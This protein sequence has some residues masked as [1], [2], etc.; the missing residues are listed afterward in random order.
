[1][2]KNVIFLLFFIFFISCKDHSQNYKK[3][4]LNSLIEVNT[5]EDSLINVF[6]EP[7]R[8]SIESE[9]NE[10]IS[11][12][13][14]DLIKNKPVGNLGNFITNLCLSY[15]EADICIM[16]NGGLRSS[17]NKGNITV[18][19]IYELMPFENEL[20]IVELS[21]TDFFEMLHHIIIEKGGEPISGVKVVATNKEIIDYKPKFKYEKKQ[22][23]K[24]LTS[25]YLA[26][27][28]EFFKTK[29]QIKIG[30]K[31]RDAI[32]NYCK[33]NDTIYSKVDDRIK[34]ID[35]EK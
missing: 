8:T 28:K 16:N 13:K 10:I 6:I 26:D 17:I 25:D 22:K 30:I 18:G 31:L 21:K 14:S 23:I 34:I 7:Y 24:I 29:E 33:N 5:H 35:N 27:K 2:I 9:M 12:T 15:A 19:M 11:F 3:Q 4:Y 1:M 32:I 20:V